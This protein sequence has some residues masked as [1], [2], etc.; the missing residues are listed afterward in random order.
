[1]YSRYKG[2]EPPSTV[3]TGASDF[4]QYDHEFLAKMVLDDSDVEM[5]VTDVE[6]TVSPRAGGSFVRSIWGWGW[7]DFA[8]GTM[9]C[10]VRR[11]CRNAKRLQE[12]G[13]KIE[14]V[15]YNV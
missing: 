8:D 10:F 13:L 3:P 5:I 9:G 11:L 15:L 1:M 12:T 6:V 14:D 4:F 2:V 7:G